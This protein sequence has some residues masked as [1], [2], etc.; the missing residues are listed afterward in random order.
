M[1]AEDY[2]NDFY[3]SM[4]GEKSGAIYYLD[5][6]KVIKTTT[7]AYLI[8]DNDGN[9]EWIPRSQSV[10]EPPPFLYMTEKDKIF[11]ISEWLVAK[12]N[13]NWKTCDWSA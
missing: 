6:F 1:A 3:P 12:K 5:E 9:R 10:I 13:L 2:I 11:T 7:K 4:R 8:E